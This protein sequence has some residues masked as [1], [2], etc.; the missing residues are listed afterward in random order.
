MYAVELADREI[1]IPDPSELSTCSLVWGDEGPMPR[2]PE[3]SILALSEPAVVN[4]NV[5]AVELNTPV[6]VSPLNV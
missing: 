6:L 1:L 4:C 3:L 2:F 5:S